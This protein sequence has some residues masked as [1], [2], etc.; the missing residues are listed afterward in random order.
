MNNTSNIGNSMVFSG[1]SIK[2]A[3]LFRGYTM[4]DLADFSG[5]SQ[6]MISKYEKN[7]SIPTVDVLG[8]LSNFLGFPPQ[9]FY[10]EQI[11]AEANSGF[12]RKASKV[13]KRDK[14]RVAEFATYADKILNVIKETI[15]LPQYNDPV[16]INRT[17]EWQDIS[18]EYIEK[19]SLDIRD[20]YKLGTGPLINLTGLMESLGIIITYSDI[21][22]TKIDAYTTYIEG[23]PIIILNANKKSAVRVRFNLAHEL[24][25]ILFHRD[26]KKKYENGGK[27]MRIE[28][29]ANFFAGCFLVPEQG[30]LDDLSSI[31]LQHL[32]VLKGHWQVSVA[33]LITRS[34]QCNFFSDTHALHLWQQMS[35][36]GWRLAEPLDDSIEMEKPV[37]LE[38]AFNLYDKKNNGNGIEV[39]SNRLR[40]FPEFV[41]K[42][43]FFK[44]ETVKKAP[45]L[46]LL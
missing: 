36:N 34:N 7:K 24:A 9:Y 39:I 33:A 15:I 18:F 30:L 1:E 29:E 6:Q 27:Y 22:N 40:L 5:V 12:Y 21:E 46:K 38:Q 43:L 42:V 28:E 41:E 10:S 35:R 45:T 20:K 16:E 14:Q 23:T 26:Y 13:S 37:L 44:K 32:V 25:H 4:E 2:K 19:V 3:R 31:N 11:I 8:K 17:T